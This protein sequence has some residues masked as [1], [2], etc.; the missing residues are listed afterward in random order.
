MLFG[1]IRPARLA[2]VTAALVVACGGCG[3]DRPAA[4]TTRSLVTPTTQIAG[5]GVLGN[6]RRPDESCA[7]D[8][9]EADPGPA[10]RQVHNAPGGDPAPVQVSADPRRIVVLAG[11]Q[12]DALCALGL[13]SRVVGAALPDGASGQPAY[14]GGAVRGVPGVGSRSHPDVKAIAAAHPDLILGSQGLT[15]ALYPQLAAIAPTVF[16]AAP[17]AA[18]RDNLRAVGAATARAGAVDGLL[19]GF[20]QRAG[21]VGARHD[22]SHFQASIVQLTTGSIRVFGA[23]NFPASVLGAVG[24]DRPAAQRF[25]DKPYLEIGATDADL[26]KNPDLSVADADV[27]YLSCATPAAADR[28]A[29]VLDSGPWRKLSA[30][31]DNRVYVVNDE[32]W[33][34][35]QGLIA[36]RG[37][38]DD[39]RLVNAPIN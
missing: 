5:A 34:T 3:S 2:A 12:L 38:V 15:P 8:A 27:V 26:A 16:T 36:A 31:R 39:L 29:T 7:R 25:T 14:L 20:S 21:D 17:G 35:G 1:V 10:K 9:A 13:Q 33:Q 18:W 6:D 32:I 24:V 28:A 11:D 22:A 4:T 37:I 23:N 19:S 30:N